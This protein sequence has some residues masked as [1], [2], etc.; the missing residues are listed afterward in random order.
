MKIG[1]IGLG[2]MGGSIVKRLK[3]YDENTYIIAYDT[4]IEEL[5]IAKHEKFIDNYTTEIGKS[6][7]NLDYIFICSPVKYTIDIA[8]EL[9]SIVQNDCLVIDIGSTKGSIVPVLEDMN[10]NYVGTHPMVG[11]ELSGFRYSDSHLYD[12]AYFLITVTNKTSKV[13]L[14][15]AIKIIQ[16]LDAVPYTIP[17]EKH[18]FI[19]SAISH[20][21]HI[22]AFSLVNMANNL[23]DENEYL[24]TLAAGGFK[25]ITR[26]ASSSPK[27]WQAIFK[28]NKE[29]ILN[30]LKFFKS[31]IN[32]LEQLIQ[33]E[34][35]NEIEKFIESSKNYRDSIDTLKKNNELD[36]KIQNTPGE[37]AKIIN[38]LGENNINIINLSILD[39]IDEK[40]GTLKLFFN[41]I[42]MKDLAQKT[43]KENGVI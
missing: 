11:K 30:T 8:K 37:L 19:V 9:E 15:K 42:D 40:H 26:I 18:D 28:E 34:N 22:V 14:E 1:I 7:S 2:L 21:P 39:D 20:V 13:N 27:M 33:E 23:D 24:K 41:N 32:N 3:K 5:E 10:F 43:L 38:I 16:I 4:N 25:D 29:E 35:S 6:F 12:K 31:S 17:L 36:L